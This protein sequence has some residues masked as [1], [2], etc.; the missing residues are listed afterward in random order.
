VIALVSVYEEV[1][2][3]K[4]LYELLRERSTED[5]LFVNI[6]HRALPT[7]GDHVKFI[8][9]D[10]YRFWYLIKAGEMF[11]GTV[12]LSHQNEI[13]ITLFKS[14]RGNGYGT[15]AVSALIEQHEPLPAIPGKRRG[16]FLAN[17]NPSNSRSIQM[18]EKLGAR[19]VQHTY[20]ID[21]DR[22]SQR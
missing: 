12:F 1:N 19:L 11:V 22:Y 7:W 20:E 18:F 5:D 8:E 16:V 13:G 10:P 17:I 3:E 9:S 14:Q 21:A 4:I 6:S 2:A 15:A